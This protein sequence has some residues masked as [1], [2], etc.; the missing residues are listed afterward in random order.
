MGP[1]H[2][3]AARAA[4]PCRATLA[5]SRSPPTARA[6]RDRGE[7]DGTVRRW[8]PAARKPVGEPLRGHTTTVR[9]LAFNGQ[10][11]VLASAGDDATVL[12]PW[13]LAA[14]R[15]LGQPLTGHTG[16]IPALALSPNGNTLASAGQ[17]GTVR[18]WDVPGRAC[19]DS[20]SPA[21][22][23]PSP[24]SPSAR[25]EPCS[26]P[27]DHRTVRLWQSLLWS[28]DWSAFRDRICTSVRRSLSASEQDEF[29]TGA[30]Y[31]PSC[32]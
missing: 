23:A 14:D 2:P 9:A 17:D 13:D 11:T 4:I 7:A 12:G 16:A 15:Q 3:S 26:P 22:P 32:S 19:S 18:V 27:P 8:E 21:I 30:A 28:Q 5:P 6:N 29:L 1:P 20:R 10:G 24:P 25:T 31:E